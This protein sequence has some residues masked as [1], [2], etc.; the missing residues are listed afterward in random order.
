MYKSQ[1]TH[2][3]DIEARNKAFNALSK[4]D[5]RKEIALDC[6]NLTLSGKIKAAIGEYWS[7]E[8][9]CINPKNAKLFQFELVNN[10]P[11]CQVCA[12]GGMMLS[13]IRLGNSIS[14][15]NE[16]RMDGENQKLLKGFTYESFEKMESEYEWSHY[17][18]PYYHRTTQKLQ[19]I[20]LNV[21]YNGDFKPE[22]KTDYLT[23]FIS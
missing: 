19:N 13:Q 5:K 1:L 2:I 21:I 7:H 9:E 14:P 12:R 4:S 22:D 20:C 16:D 17:K 15:K 23:T 6:L 3:T 10:L 18:H 11:E 8:L